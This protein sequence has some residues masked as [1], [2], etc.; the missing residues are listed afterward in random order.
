MTRLHLA[1]Y[2]GL[3]LVVRLLVEKGADV[4]AADKDGQTPLYQASKNGY[5]EIV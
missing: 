3:E 4:K 2:F 5:L 1:A